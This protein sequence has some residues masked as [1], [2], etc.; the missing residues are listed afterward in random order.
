MLI[1]ARQSAVQPLGNVT[2]DSFRPG[3]AA[4]GRC[5]RSARV[6]DAMVDLILRI[7][8]PK[9]SV[10]DVAEHVGIG[11]GTVYKHWNSKEDIID[12]VLV[13]EFDRVH[14]QFMAH[15]PGDRRM[16]TLHGTSCVLYRLVMANPVLRAYNTRDGRVLG[17]HVAAQGSPDALGISLVSVLGRFPYL[18]LLRDH[19]LIVDAVCSPEGQL[20][21]EAVVSGFVARAGHADDLEETNAS[22]RM[23]ATVLRRAFEPV[24]PPEP[25]D[26]DRM[27]KAMLAARPL[28]S[29]TPMRATPTTGER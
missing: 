4:G 8:Y 6:L 22:S 21:I 7:G 24:D 13:R 9:I 1:T 20:S 23:M 29:G 28:R 10:Q 27:T 14:D 19:G 16:A 5:T 2:T 15:L 25:A 3:Q 26:H 18:E 11:K 12:D 17:T